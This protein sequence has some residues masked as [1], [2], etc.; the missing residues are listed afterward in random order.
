MDGMAWIAVIESM[1]GT[2]T[3]PYFSHPYMQYYYRHH[4]HTHTTT[5]SP[6][7]PQVSQELVKKHLQDH[8]LSEGL[9]VALKRWLEVLPDGSL[10]NVKIR[11]TVLQQLQHMRINLQDDM[12]RTQV[13]RWMGER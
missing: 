7:Y 12:R 4:Y 3:R 9:L 2:D 11:T 8:L 13:G 6:P 5:S 10:P 1:A